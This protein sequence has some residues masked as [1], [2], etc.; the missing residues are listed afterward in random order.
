MP[1]EQ[2]LH[3]LGLGLREGARPTEGRIRGVLGAADGGLVPREAV[4]AVE[5]DP[6][7]LGAV[8]EGAQAVGGGG[9][10]APVLALFGQHVAVGVDHGHHPDLAVVHGE[11]H[12]GVLAVVG[13][14]VLGDHVGDLGG[15]E[16]A[17]V[18]LAQE[19]DPGLGVGGA[20][21]DAQAPDVAVG[22]ALALLPRVAQ[23]HQFAELGVLGGEAL[24]VRDHLLVGPVLGVVGVVQAHAAAVGG[25]EAQLL[26]G[27]DGA[28]A[29]GAVGHVVGDAPEVQLV[30]DQLGQLVRGLVG[31][32]ERHAGL[33][34]EGLHQGAL[35]PVARGGQGQGAAGEDAE[36]QE[37]RPE[38]RG[39]DAHAFGRLLLQDPGLA[40]SVIRF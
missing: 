25:R 36:R 8:A 11:G 12:V 17:G 32:G 28:L 26:G 18:M 19:G 15:D 10:L 21:A 4:V 7:A 35:T 33:G 27:L 38:T 23:V 14:Q 30:V 2:G 13:Q 5:V 3:G 40:E 29:T 1:G 37:A 22:L 20:G 6:R 16:L 9:A 24:H 39:G 31:D 34:L